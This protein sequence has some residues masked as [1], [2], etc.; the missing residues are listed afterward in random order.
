MPGHVSCRTV[1]LV[2]IFFLLLH[3]CMFSKKTEIDV[4]PSHSKKTEIDGAL[5]QSNQYLSAGDGQKAIDTLRTMHAKYPEDK[6][7]LQSYQKAVEEMKDSSDRAFDTEEFV[8]AGRSYRLLLRNYRHFR[9]F[10]R[11]L[12]F[13]K[14]YLSARITYCSEHLF[15][16]GVEEYRNGDIRVAISTWEG[17]LSFDPE[18]AEASKAYDAATTQLK[19][20]QQKN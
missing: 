11:Q 4:A 13:D 1:M 18:N 2:G 6:P 12:S 19:N 16:R 14:K 15:K 3:A 10:A 20:L 8:S 9:D 17:L 5:R 7:L